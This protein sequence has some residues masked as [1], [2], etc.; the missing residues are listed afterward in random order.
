M[1][2]IFISVLEE[3]LLSMGAWAVASC[4]TETNLSMLGLFK[5]LW[6]GWNYVTNSTLCKIEI[7]P[8]AL[9]AYPVI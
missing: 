8:V 7:F 9:L 4:N 1:G 2:L 6:F 5:L 3:L